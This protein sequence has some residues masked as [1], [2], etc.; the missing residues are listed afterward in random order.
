[1]GKIERGIKRLCQDCGALYY[2]LDKNPI[3]CPKCG[4]EFD[5][6]AIL[7]SRRA[8]PMTPNGKENTKSQD[9]ETDNSED[10]DEVETTL[11]D[12]EEG[13]VVDIRSDVEVD[14]EDVVAVVPDDEDI[15]DN[16]AVLDDGE[17]LEDDLDV[18]EDMLKLDE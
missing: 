9:E 1:L 13:E 15:L 4:A 14:S 18:E 12:D 3:I 7:K 11:E 5:P 8:R 16:E 10:L 2:D 17:E 6:E